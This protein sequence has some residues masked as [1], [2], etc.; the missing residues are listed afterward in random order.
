MV[1]SCVLGGASG[2]LG[3]ASGVLGGVFC[4]ALAS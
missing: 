3:G 2:V 1:A 4:A